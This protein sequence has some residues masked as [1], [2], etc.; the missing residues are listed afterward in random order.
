VSA[1]ACR[2]VWRD[3]LTHPAGSDQFFTIPSMCLTVPSKSGQIHG[4]SEKDSRKEQGDK[5][6]RHNWQG[7]LFQLV[8]GGEP[9]TI[10]LDVL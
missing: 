4:R 8:V 3:L 1:Q 10:F 7:E 9:K 5:F 2:L 6:R